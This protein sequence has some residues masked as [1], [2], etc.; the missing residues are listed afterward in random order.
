MQLFVII[1][2]FVFLQSVAVL[3]NIIPKMLQQI[4]RDMYVDPEILAELPEEQKEMLFFK[5]RQEQVSEASGSAWQ[6]NAVKYET[7]EFLQKQAAK[8]PDVMPILSPI[9]NSSQRLAKKLLSPF[10]SFVLPHYFSLVDLF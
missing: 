5:I 10:A 2:F 8:N 7:K 4:L 1:L 3:L 9:S 6:K